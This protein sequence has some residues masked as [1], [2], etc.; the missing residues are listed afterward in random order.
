MNR[1]LAQ[2]SLLFIK[3][4]TREYDIMLHEYAGCPRSNLEYNELGLR[5]GCLLC[6]LLKAIDDE[7]K[8]S[9]DHN[10]GGVS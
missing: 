1:S 10:S 2:L 9:Q 5:K 8:T 7:L 4:I 3:T 6:L